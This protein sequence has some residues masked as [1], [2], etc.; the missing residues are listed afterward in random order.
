MY[1]LRTADVFPV[2]ASLPPKNNVLFFGGRE[3][4]AGDT[5]AVRRLPCVRI[6]IL[7]PEPTNMCT[8]F[9]F[10]S[11]PV[12]LSANFGGIVNLCSSGNLRAVKVKLVSPA[13]IHVA[14]YIIHYI[15]KI[16]YNYLK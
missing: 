13:Y 10:Q 12:L 7:W 8:V 2:V 16:I 11:K 14:A 1:S 15:T 5:S 3:A 9:C 4:T 6:V